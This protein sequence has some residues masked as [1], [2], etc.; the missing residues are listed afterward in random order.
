M[1]PLPAIFVLWYSRIHIGTVNYSNKASYIEVSVNDFLGIR[2]ILGIPDVNLNDS[3]IRLGQ[4]LDNL[5]FGS[6]DDIVENMVVLEN[7]FDF[8]Q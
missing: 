1:P 8:I 4:N 6:E 5:R 7:A 3:Y 2:P